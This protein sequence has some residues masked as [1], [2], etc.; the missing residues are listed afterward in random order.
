MCAGDDEDFEESLSNEQHDLSVLPAH[1]MQSE[2]VVTL[3]EDVVPNAGAYYLRSLAG[4]E[5]DLDGDELD[6]Y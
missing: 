6:R 4:A 3:A 5:A 2:L 1:V